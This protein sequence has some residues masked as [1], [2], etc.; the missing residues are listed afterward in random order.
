MPLFRQRRPHQLGLLA[1]CA[2]AACAAQAQMLPPTPPQALG[3]VE[4]ADEPQT[5]E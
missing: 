5:L 3:L 2:L 4:P 1:L